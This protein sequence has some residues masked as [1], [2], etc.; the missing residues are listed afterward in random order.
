MP[1]LIFVNRFFYPDHSATSQV[2]FD[3]AFDL[4]GTGREVHVVTSTQIYDHAQA[5]LPDHETVNGVQSIASPRHNSDAALCSAARPT[6]CHFT[7]RF[8]DA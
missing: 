2:L 1:K 5:S 7:G 8:A 6:I 4:A 3:L